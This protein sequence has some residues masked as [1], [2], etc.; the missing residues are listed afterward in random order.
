[1]IFKDFYKDLQTVPC[2]IT[3]Y[4]YSYFQPLWK[5][6]VIRDKY[7]LLYSS[8]LYLYISKVKNKVKKLQRTQKHFF[9]S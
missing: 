8:K 9:F 7:V 5:N 3:I 2:L 6:K 1:M 4:K